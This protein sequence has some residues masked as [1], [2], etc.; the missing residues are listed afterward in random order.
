MDHTNSFFATI[1]ENSSPT[2]VTD[3]SGRI[4]YVNRPALCLLEKCRPF[5]RPS[6]NINDSD[7]SSFINS[8]YTSI[9]EPLD[10]YE[11]TSLRNHFMNNV[12][13]LSK[14]SHVC[15][16]IKCRTF[17][18]KRPVML[19]FSTRTCT[20]PEFFNSD[21]DSSGE[22]KFTISPSPTRNNDMYLRNSSVISSDTSSSIDGKEGSDSEKGDEGGGGD[23]DDDENEQFF[24]ATEYLDNNNLEEQSNKSNNYNDNE[25]YKRKTLYNRINTVVN[26]FNSKT[27]ITN[28]SHLLTVVGSTEGTKNL[29]LISTIRDV[30]D[31]K[32][33][34]FVLNEADHRMSITYDVLGVIS[35]VSRSCESILGYE[36]DELLGND[37]YNFIHPDDATKIRTL[38]A[39]RAVE[40]YG[41]TLQRQ[42]FRHLKKDGSYCLL[43][44]WSQGLQPDGSWSFIGFDITDASEHLMDNR[45]MISDQTFIRK[46]LPKNVEGESRDKAANNFVSFICHGMYLRY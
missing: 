5:K 14:R 11:A 31:S 10:A 6:S 13:I 34:E 33:Q 26:N 35:E 18:S 23:D 46:L 12:Q 20:Y 27:Q 7:P 25:L 22:K 19:E 37:G 36:P 39:K 41:T 43:E 2:L 29:I 30:T 42:A 44:I 24:D 3:I 16:T 15:R 17:S 1:L 28:D 38:H 40:N 8:H 32:F 21:N 4:L 45:N 9:I